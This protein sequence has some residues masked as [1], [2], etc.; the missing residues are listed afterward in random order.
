[1]SCKLDIPFGKSVGSL[2]SSVLFIF[3]HQVTRKLKNLENVFLFN[4]DM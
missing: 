2:P 4:D 3:P 1:M